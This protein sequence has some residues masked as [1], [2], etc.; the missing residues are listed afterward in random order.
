MNSTVRNKTSFNTEA[1]RGLPELNTNALRQLDA[2][3][4]SSKSNRSTSFG[5]YHVGKGSP[6][7]ALFM[8]N[9]ESLED[10]LVRKFKTKYLSKD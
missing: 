5:A 9:R 1:D 3:T 6:T 10:M 8:K 7:R 2:M 4:K